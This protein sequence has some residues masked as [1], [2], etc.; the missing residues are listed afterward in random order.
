MAFCALAFFDTAPQYTS[1]HS[2]IPAIHPNTTTFPQGSMCLATFP[3][4]RFRVLAFLPLGPV[5][6]PPPPRRIHSEALPVHRYKHPPVVRDT[7]VHPSA[8]ESGKVPVT[9]LH[10]PVRSADS[11][12]ESWARYRVACEH[13]RAEYECSF[14]G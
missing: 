4:A 5:E 13:I 11:I 12:T 1:L 6:L 9:L 3:P 8:F 7:S 2:R 14:R 10:P